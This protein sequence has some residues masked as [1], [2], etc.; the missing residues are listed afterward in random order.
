MYAGFYLVKSF[1]RPLKVAAAV[2]LRRHFEQLLGHL[3][4]RLSVSGSK[5]TFIGFFLTTALG[6]LVCLPTG[7]LIA[8]SLAGVPIFQ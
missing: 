6:L 8:S 7:V 5:A 4:S 2:T 3:Q 1:L